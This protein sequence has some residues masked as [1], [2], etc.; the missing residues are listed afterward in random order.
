LAVRVSAARQEHISVHR[1]LPRVR[2]DREPPLMW[3]RT[4]EIFEV[5]WV[6]REEE[7]FF[8][9]GVDTTP[10]SAAQAVPAAD[11]GDGAQCQA[12]QGIHLGEP[13]RRHRWQE[14]HDVR[15]MGQHR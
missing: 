14:G 11:G 5:I 1:I 8:Q 6:W 10:K 3:D 12:S 13:A 15:A 4:V 7:I 9:G 2:D